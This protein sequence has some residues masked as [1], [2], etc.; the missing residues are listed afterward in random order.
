MNLFYNFYTTNSNSLNER[1]H[2]ALVLFIK[3]LLLVK[4]QIDSLQFTVQK[5]SLV[6]LAEEIKLNL[7][8]LSQDISLFE[9]EI[10]S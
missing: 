3:R 1:N 8:R 2:K 7:F 4:K 9:E 5:E 10:S 6:Y